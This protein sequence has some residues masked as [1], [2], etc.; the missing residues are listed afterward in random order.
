MDLA[1]GFTY[2]FYLT[3]LF[4]WSL[5]AGSLQIYWYVSDHDFS[6]RMLFL[7]SFLLSGLIAMLW[8]FRYVIQ[9]PDNSRNFIYGNFINGYRIP[10]D[11]LLLKKMPI[12]R[13][14]YKVSVDSATFYI[15]S[16]EETVNEYIK[17]NE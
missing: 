11:S 2:G 10:K 3:G 13:G 7:F 15:L 17:S 5:F 12:A 14:I 9:D 8:K 6:W 16:D 1:T 4:I